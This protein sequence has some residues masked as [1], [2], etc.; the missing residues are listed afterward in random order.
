MP[1]S[2]FE[3]LFLVTALGT[4]LSYN[5]KAGLVSLWSFEQGTNNSNNVI[6]R[7]DCLNGRSSGLNKTREGRYGKAW[8]SNGD[9]NYIIIRNQ[10]CLQT[11]NLSNQISI[12]IWIQCR[13]RTDGQG[14]SQRHEIIQGVICKNTR[15]KLDREYSASSPTQSYITLT[16]P[17]VKSVIPKT[18][19]RSNALLNDGKWYHVVGTYDGLNVSLYIDGK[20]DIQLPAGGPIGSADSPILIGGNGRRDGWFRG[21]IDEVALFDH[22][23]TPDE[24]MLLYDQGISGLLS[25]S[26][27]YLLDIYPKYMQIVNGGNK[28][29]V[30][31]AL[32][33]LLIPFVNIHDYDSG[34]VS[35]RFARLATNM[36]ASLAE[37]S[38]NKNK[39]QTNIVKLNSYGTDYIQALI[40]LYSNTERRKFRELVKSSYV[41]NHYVRQAG[42]IIKELYKQNH[43]GLLNEYLDIVFSIAN[44]RALL[45]ESIVSVLDQ[46]VYY[47]WCQGNPFL[48]RALIKH[49]DG[50]AAQCIKKSE[51][52]QA[53]TI[54]EKIMQIS[55]HND[56]NI[57]VYE[58]KIARSLIEQGL[59]RSAIK[60]LDAFIETYQSSHGNLVNQARILK[61]RICINFRELD[62]A[63]NTLIAASIDESD[64]NTA[65]EAIFLLGYGNMV[66]GR[67]KEAQDMFNMLDKHYP[68]THSSRRAKLCLSE[69]GKNH[70]D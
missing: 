56:L 23:L 69:I 44:D 15:W 12:S 27:K 55:Q 36:Y 41:D 2:T 1:K 40:W 26:E 34:T 24:V 10:D 28:S 62:S 67:T 25:D 29:Q 8:T 38:T 43:W 47:Q 61:G 49:L 39:A 58:L 66:T 20:L 50:M 13:S 64:T 33:E 22:G 54:Y 63:Y 57:A 4:L 70:K 3:W 60:Q 48:E 65:S 5:A 18:S 19:L 52:Q 31:E 17:K 30:S 9:E 7:L 53:R 35:S 11:S 37:H 42:Y 59:L 16:L 6:D 14:I 51:H 68:N 21:A 32:E 46:D 45:A